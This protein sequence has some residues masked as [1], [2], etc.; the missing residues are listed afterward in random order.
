MALKSQ[1][2]LHNS[3]LLGY[4]QVIVHVLKVPNCRV[5]AIINAPV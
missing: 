1:Q 5:S 4:L 2:L 3:A